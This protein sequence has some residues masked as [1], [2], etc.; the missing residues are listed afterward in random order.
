M[1]KQK[2]GGNVRIPYADRVQLFHDRAEAGRFLAE[3]LQ[4]YAQMPDVVVCALPRGGVPV[5][6]EIATALEVPLTVYVMRKLGVPGHEEL[7]MGALTSGGMRLINWPVVNSLRI[8][9]NAIETTIAREQQELERR[10]RLYAR[11]HSLPEFKHKIVILT[12]D[13]IATGASITLAVRALRQKGARKIVVA[14][15]VSA[16][17]ATSELRRIADE[18]VSLC[19]PE[20]FGSVG[21][22]YEHFGQLDDREVCRILDRAFQHVPESRPA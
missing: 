10:E 8:P 20:R 2:R 6:A 17:E 14:V 21:Q 5:G 13:G 4:A 11:G 18:V 7:A 9:V 22:W 1:M 15:P 19:E 16:P 3:R 12:D